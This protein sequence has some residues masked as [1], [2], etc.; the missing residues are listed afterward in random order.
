MLKILE[1]A[2]ADCNLCSTPVDLNSKL[3]ADGASFSDLTDF[4]SLAVL[5]SGLLSQDQIS[6]T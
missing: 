3:S 6:R 4:C 5:C 2:V 1:R